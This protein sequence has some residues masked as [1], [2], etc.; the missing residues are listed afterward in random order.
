LEVIEH[1][2]G[3]QVGDVPNLSMSVGLA[4]KISRVKSR[5]ISGKSA[6]ISKSRLNL[7]CCS[8]QVQGEKREGSVTRGI[9]ASQQSPRRRRKRT[10][11]ASR[12][13]DLGLTCDAT[14]L[15]PGAADA[16]PSISLTG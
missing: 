2:E 10:S 16:A 12:G 5:N 14:G 11:L 15:G 1:G 8:R 7:T 4:R 6:G 3:A 13:L 9:Q